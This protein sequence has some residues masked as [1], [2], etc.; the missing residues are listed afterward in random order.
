[1]VPDVEQQF[2]DVHSCRGN[3]HFQAGQD[4]FVEAPT[5]LLG[6]L[7]KGGVNG[8][9]NIFQGDGFHICNHITTIMVVNHAGS[10][11]ACHVLP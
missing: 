10:K 5:V 8:A 6:P 1:M 4:F 3:D 2:V 9:R 7:L 11:E